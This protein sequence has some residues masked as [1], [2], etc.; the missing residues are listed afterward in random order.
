M[1]EQKKFNKLTALKHNEDSDLLRTLGVDVFALENRI[2]QVPDIDT[3]KIVAL[4]NRIVA[5]EYAIKLKRLADKLLILES[6]LE[7]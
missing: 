2:Q 5:G 3:A 4:H 1:E 6:E 7:L